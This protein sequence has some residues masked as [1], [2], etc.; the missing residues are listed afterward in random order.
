MKN[1]IFFLLL[2]F[3]GPVWF[4]ILFEFFIFIELL[5]M[6]LLIKTAFLYYIDYFKNIFNITW[7]KLFS[8]TEK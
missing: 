3:S 1:K 2:I 4:A 7:R 8:T 5:G 6:S